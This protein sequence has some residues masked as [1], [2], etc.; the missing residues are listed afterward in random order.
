M[1]KFALAL[2]LLFSFTVQGNAN[3]VKEL[4]ISNSGNLSL[5]EIQTISRWSKVENLELIVT[6][7][8]QPD[9]LTDGYHENENLPAPYSTDFIILDNIGKNLPLS[10]FDSF[11]QHVPNMKKCTFKNIAVPCSLSFDVPDRLW[12][13]DK[14]IFERGFKASISLQEGAVCFEALEAQSKESLSSYHL[15]YH[16]GYTKDPLVLGLLKDAIYIGPQALHLTLEKNQSTEF[17][18]PKQLRYIDSQGLYLLKNVNVKIEESDV[19]LVIS[20]AGIAMEGVINKFEFNRPVYLCD[21]ALPY[22]EVKELIFNDNVEYLGNKSFNKIETVRF[23]ECPKKMGTIVEYPKDIQRAYVPSSSLTQFQNFGVSYIKSIIGTKEQGNLA[24]AG[25]QTEQMKAIEEGRLLPS[26][27]FIQKNIPILNISAIYPK[28]INFYNWQMLNLCKEDVFAYTGRQG[29]D[30]LDKAFYMKSEDYQTDLNSLQEDKNRI[31]AYMYDLANDSYK[32]NKQFW[33]SFDVDGI[34]FDCSNLTNNT[35]LPFAHIGVDEL[36]FPV[37]P[38]VTLPG[39]GT[40]YKFAC[41]DLDALKKVKDNLG[42]IAF[43]ILFKP[44][45]AK[46]VSS[47]LQSKAVGVLNPVAIYILDKNSGDVVLNLSEHIRDISSEAGYKAEIELIENGNKKAEAIQEKWDKEYREA[48][49]KKKYHQVPKEERCWVCGG[50]GY[51][52]GVNLDGVLGRTQSRCTVCYGRG[53]TL[54]HYY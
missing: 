22:S 50:K 42:R 45:F 29:M 11:L 20:G 26:F 53:Y 48:Q 36:A 13:Y 5:K 41:S 1:R 32:N 49:A 12:I 18:I 2:F 39:Y 37:Q 51:N 54:E 47:F 21:S 27:D 52:T 6:I 28:T 10:I 46:E 3:N 16:I 19:P 4:K 43:V 7:S 44:A 15:I 40:K 35:S 25:E 34:T 17:T 23:K 38:E 9:D 24:N 8:N 31:Y 14:R 33:A 30:E